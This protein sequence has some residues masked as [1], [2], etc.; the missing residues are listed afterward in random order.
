MPN[1]VAVRPHLSVFADFYSAKLYKNAVLQEEGVLSVA[2]GVTSVFNAGLFVDFPKLLYVAGYNLVPNIGFE[3]CF[4][5]DVS[6]LYATPILTV[7]CRLYFDK[8][9][10][11]PKQQTSNTE[12]QDSR[13]EQLA[14]H[15]EQ[16]EVPV[17]LSETKDLPCKIDSSACPLETSPYGSLRVQNDS[18][19]PQ[20]DSTTTNELQPE[21]LA[22]T[23]TFAPIIFIPNET[24]PIDFYNTTLQK[25]S[26]FLQA[27]PTCTLKITGY[28]SPIFERLSGARP[29]DDYIKTLS[30]HR[31]ES[32][33][34]QLEVLGIQSER[35]NA[36]GMGGGT[37]DSQNDWQNRRVEFECVLQE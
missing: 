36:Q 34:N 19:V 24:V 21:Q 29:D 18:V 11:P 28:A 33:K 17:I 35:L 26:E 9:T 27:N 12:Q 23:P 32:V 8:K 31:A 2:K 15:T 16:S 13:T 25:I 30:Q 1:F 37:Y 3:E 10:P 6:G 7:G 5:F 14:R 4:R 20:N 22:P